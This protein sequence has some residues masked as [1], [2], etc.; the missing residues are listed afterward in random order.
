MKRTIR[1]R[2]RGRTYSVNFVTAEAMQTHPRNFGECDPRDSKNPVIN[3]RANQ[4][5]LN[6]LDTIIHEA[7][8]AAQPDLKE[9]AVIEVSNCISSLLWKLGYRR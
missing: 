8:H 1:H 9:D 6:L 4:R 7:T 3:I 5:E 2:F